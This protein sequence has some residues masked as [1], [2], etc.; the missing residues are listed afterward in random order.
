LADGALLEEQARN[1]P[2]VGLPLMQCEELGQRFI[3]GSERSLEKQCRKE[4]L[5]AYEAFARSEPGAE[6]QMPEL[7]NKGTAL[8]MQRGNEKYRQ[9]AAEICI[10]S[11]RSIAD[12]ARMHRKDADT[13]ES[14][15][16]HAALFMTNYYLAAIF[17]QGNRG[18]SYQC[19]F[20]EDAY[21]ALVNIRQQGRSGGYTLASAKTDFN[22][23][24]I[25]PCRNRGVTM[26]KLKQIEKELNIPSDYNGKTGW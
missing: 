1:H 23:N 10:T 14:D 5:D 15:P 21:S 25:R 6:R 22:R 8:C 13:R 7:L 4:A 3:G 12:Y 26:D 19:K 9:G 18:N 11:K 16:A 24:Y 2:E 17:E 20:L